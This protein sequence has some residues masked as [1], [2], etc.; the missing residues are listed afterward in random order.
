[1]DADRALPRLA[2]VSSLYPPHL[3]GVERYTASLARALSGR[4]AVD[5]FCLNT[6]RQPAEIA[7]CGV[8]VRYLPCIPAFGG[9]LPLPTIGALRT[10]EGWIDR[11]APAAAVIQT[12]LYPL[13]AF[14]VRAFAKRRVP[15]LTI[16]HGTGYIDFHSAVFNCLWRLYERLLTGVFRRSGASFYA[17]SRAGLD[18]LANFGLQGAGVLPNGV[19]LADSGIAAK[20][21][22]S[23]VG[24]SDRDFLIVFAGRLLREK[25][26]FDLAA[27]VRSQNDPSVRLVYAGGGDSRTE[28]R[29]RAEPSVPFVGSLSHDRWLGLLQESDLLCLPTCYPEGLPTVILE[30]GLAGVPVVASPAGGI[31]EVVED[32]V[33]GRIVP[34]GDVEALTAAIR[35]LRTDAG[36]RAALG[37]ALRDRVRAGYT[38]DRI[39]EKTAAAIDR[40]RSEALR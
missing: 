14:A 21:M 33:S 8:T 18:W 11:L 27:A 25:G 13:N 37:A 16:E 29:L 30:A 39:A 6:E 5:V 38:W 10:F 26:V 28:A 1:M 2:I 35:D 23:E 4:F 7:D 22:R 31:P 12:R 34:A 24:V 9:R 17:V 20:G 36:R 3:G 15:T 40:I 19:S 32:G